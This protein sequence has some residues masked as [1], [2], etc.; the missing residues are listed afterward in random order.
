MTLAFGV[1]AF[2]A[3]AKLRERP[4]HLFALEITEKGAF[5]RPGNKWSLRVMRRGEVDG[6]QRS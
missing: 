1:E 5:R 6:K 2:E 4:I 3:E